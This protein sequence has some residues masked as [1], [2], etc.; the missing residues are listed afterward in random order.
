MSRWSGEPRDHR[1]IKHVTGCIGSMGCRCSIYE[2]LNP[3][4]RLPAYLK[5]ENEEHWLF[6]KPKD[7]DA[8]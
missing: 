8:K 6:A 2:D 5:D 3:R 7:R 1:D 4:E